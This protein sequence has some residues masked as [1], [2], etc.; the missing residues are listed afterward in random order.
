MGLGDGASVPVHAG[1]RGKT[2]VASLKV[3]VHGLQVSQDLSQ[4]CFFTLIKNLC[5]RAAAC[6]SVLY[7]NQ[8]C[9]QATAVGQRLAVT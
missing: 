2:R 6:D 4:C 1:S 8:R 3:P 5:T 7:R 9:K